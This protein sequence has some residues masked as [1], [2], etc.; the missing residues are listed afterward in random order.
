LELK[1]D[2][3]QRVKYTPEI[4]RRTLMTFAEAHKTLSKLLANVRK[5]S[6]TAQLLQVFLDGTLDDLQQQAQEEEE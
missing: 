4:R 3:G 2:D 6:D 1:L 5:A